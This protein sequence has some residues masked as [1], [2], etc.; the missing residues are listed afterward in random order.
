MPFVIPR[1]S[2]LALLAGLL[3]LTSPTFAGNAPASKPAATKPSS[4]YAALFLQPVGVHG[5]RASIDP[6]TDEFPTSPIPMTLSDAIGPQVPVEA[7]FEVQMADGSFMVNL[8][9][10][11]QHF[12]MLDPDPLAFPRRFICS[13]KSHMHG[14]PF[15]A[16]AAPAPQSSIPYIYAER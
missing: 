14:Q 11:G 2:P 16:A 1:T 4:L 8:Q 15:Q 5:L 6:V 7:L 13:D 9:G 12:L 10:T 3:L